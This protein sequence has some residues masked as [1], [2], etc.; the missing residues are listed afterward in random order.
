MR[1]SDLSLSIT[2]HHQSTKLVDAVKIL[3]D[4]YVKHKSEVFSRRLLQTLKQLAG[5]SLDQYFNLLKIFAKDCTTIAAVATHYKEKSFRDSFVH[6]IQTCYIRQSLFDL[7]ILDLDT[8]LKNA[9]ALE[10]AHKYVDSHA[11]SSYV[12]ATQASKEV[13]PAISACPP[14]QPEEPNTAFI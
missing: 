9:R 12:V 7:K 11:E 6:C 1:R 13:E 10:M 5:D 14:S 4:I 8:T 3:K 2:T